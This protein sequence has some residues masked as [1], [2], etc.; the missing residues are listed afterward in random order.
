[1]LAV[2]GAIIGGVGDIVD[3]IKHH[4]PYQ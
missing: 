1:M 3:A 2:L 4:R